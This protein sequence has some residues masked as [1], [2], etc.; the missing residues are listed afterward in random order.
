MFPNRAKKA[1]WHFHDTLFLSS[2]RRE[3]DLPAKERQS[4]FMARWRALPYR[5][6]HVVVIVFRSCSGV[7]WT[8]FLHQLVPLNKSLPR[9][10]VL[11]RVWFRSLAEGSF[12]W[13]P[14]TTLRVS[15][16]AKYLPRILQH[17]EGSSWWDHDSVERRRTGSTT[18]RKVCW[19]KLCMQAGGT[20]CGSSLL[21]VWGD[22]TSFIWVHHSPT[23]CSVC[24]L[25][26]HFWV[27]LL[28]LHLLLRPHIGWA[29]PRGFW[30]DTLTIERV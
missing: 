28:L 3:M 29:R 22:A 16:P 10:F 23:N 2:G 6:R 14:F 12:N 13:A 7:I 30:S 5:D 17:C 15:S 18:G 1:E 21:G 20:G 4:D 25:I 26:S 8:D 11:P 27:G 19:R 9:Q 24:S